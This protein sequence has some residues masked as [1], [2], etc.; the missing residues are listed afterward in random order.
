MSSVME[1]TDQP[2]TRLLICDDIAPDVDGFMA[3][4]QAFGHVYR[5]EAQIV[6][7]PSPSRCPWVPLALER[8]ARWHGFPDIPVGGWFGNG[9]PYDDVKS[10]TMCGQDEWPGYGSYAQE[11]ADAYPGDVTTEN[12]RDSVE[13]WRGVLA[14]QPDNSVT[15][16]L[17][18]FHT[19]LY[20]FL[21]SPAD[22]GGD[23]LPSG[24]DL[25][26]AKIAE[27]VVGG[28]RQGG[29]VNFNFKQAADYTGWI[30]ANVGAG[31]LVDKPLRVMPNNNSEPDGNR[32]DMQVGSAAVDQP[33]G[34]IVRYAMRSF[35]ADTA[36]FENGHYA[37]DPMTV[38]AAVRGS[39]YGWIETRGTFGIGATRETWTEDPRGPHIRL[40]NAETFQWYIDRIDP[41][42]FHPQAT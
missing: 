6:G 28:S 30:L 31:L 33:E 12:R 27:F 14:A 35:I 39:A 25:A 3:I 34:Q 22:H 18:G 11:V 20:D 24:V 40:T 26:N 2:E 38:L 42:I 32:D 5:G 9:G 4:G 17:I 10:I 13:V 15:P 36:N 21:R 37:W 41:L 7:M 1:P 23:G 8:I 16:V 19:D 29:E